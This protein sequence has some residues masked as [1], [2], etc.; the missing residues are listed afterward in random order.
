M[1]RGEAA[2]EHK[3]RGGGAEGA[4]ERTWKVWTRFPVLMSYR[5]M[6]LE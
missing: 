3:W 6:W 1:G 4:G 2:L 5:P